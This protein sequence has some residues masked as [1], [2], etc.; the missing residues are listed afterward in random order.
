[1]NNYYGKVEQ[2]TLSLY[3]F[4]IALAKENNKKPDIC[5]IVPHVY[6][7][8][9]KIFK[10]SNTNKLPLYCPSNHTILLIDRFKPLFGPLYLLSYPKLEEYKY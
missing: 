10:L 5:T 7:N 1:V 8:Y 9:L 6:H 3:K 2:F 4:N